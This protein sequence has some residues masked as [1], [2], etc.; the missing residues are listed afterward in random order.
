ME[1]SSID[2]EAAVE[3]K[4]LNSRLNRKME[5]STR[6]KTI[7]VAKVY[8]SSKHRK[9]GKCFPL[10]L[11]RQGS[12]RVPAGGDYCQGRC[13]AE[14]GA[15]VELRIFVPPDKSFRIFS[16]FLANLKGRTAGSASG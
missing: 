16:N 15:I 9:A 13:A 1:G 12:K 4:L 10:R 6:M 14:G 5:Y 7:R 2:A 11:V 8:Q 3:K